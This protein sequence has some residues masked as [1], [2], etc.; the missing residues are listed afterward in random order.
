LKPEGALSINVSNRYLDLQPVV[1]QA[2]SDMGWSGVAVSDEAEED[3]NDSAS[4]WLV[5]A[6][7]PKIFTH[8]TFKRPDVERLAA[9]PGFRAWTD[10]FSNIIQIL[11]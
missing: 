8:P 11:K 9:K 5:L 4:T 7:S 6:R 1:A 3:P 10:D 2:M